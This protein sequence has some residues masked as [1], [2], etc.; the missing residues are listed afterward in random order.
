M[1]PDEG[2]EMEVIATAMPLTRTYVG[3]EGWALRLPPVE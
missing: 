3:G 2:K 1:L